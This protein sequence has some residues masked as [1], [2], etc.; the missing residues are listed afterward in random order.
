MRISYNWLKELCPFDLSTARL[1]D[2]LS[3]AGLCVDTY[4]PLG[5]DWS[6]DVEVTSNRPDCLSML[7]IAREVAALVGVRVKHPA[8]RLAESDEAVASCAGLEVLDR[9]LCPHYTAR[10][11]RN[12]TVAPSPDWMLKRLT[13]CGLRPV[14]NVVDITNYVMLEMGQPLHA[15]DLDK[16]HGPMIKV[17]R[18][19]Q[20]EAMTAIDG[21]ECKLTP[22]MCVIADA[23]RAVAIAGVM[24]GLDTEIGDG[25]RHVLLEAA[26]FDPRTNRRTSR[27]LSL[28]SDSS[29]RFERGVDP[30]GVE[31]ASRRAAQLICELAGG[32]LAAGLLED[33]GDQAEPR[34]VTLRFAR[35]EHVLGIE[36]PRERCLQIFR[37]L[38]LDVLEENDTS[39]RVRVPSFRGD[40][41]REIDLIEEVA[42]FHGYDKISETTGIPVKPVRITRDE[43]AMNVTRELLVA[44]GFFEILT[45][46][47]VGEEP[48]Q[49]LN[50]WGAA[51]GLELRTCLSK[52]RTHLRRSLLGNLLVTKKW[53]QDRGTRRVNLFELSKV[54]LPVSGQKLP[55]EK[56]CLSALSDEDD[57]LFVLKGMLQAAAARLGL[58]GKL[59]ERPA[60]FELFQAGAVL[61]V[62][63]DGKRIGLMGVLAESWV[64]RLGLITTPALMEIDFDR[65]LAVVDFDRTYRPLPQFPAIER[66]LAIVLD[67][68]VLWSQIE[69][70][71]RAH[72]PEWMES[73]QFFDI[74]RGKQVPAG[75]K[76]VA[77][78]MTF[79]GRDRTLRSEE[80]DQ[81]QAAILKGLESGL[82]AQLR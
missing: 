66:D 31:R 29:Y 73:I 24:G 80:A 50:P 42:R 79:R 67:E 25:T 36:V 78:S 4:E 51:A 12:V 64:E 63:L 77:F 40:L 35:L 2:M 26:R 9:D 37:S 57:A 62:V 38:E 30:D 10:V 7:G 48:L 6:I 76:S 11:V 60:E 16:L 8:I 3:G 5:D 46:S 69:A 74:Y 44:G 20:D 39:V 32:T 72:A 27:A 13:A 45:S 68:S 1:C 54:Y 43:R 21:T 49:Q 33:R 82:G 17:R 15:F 41:E 23:D 22:E 28:Q 34:D 70:C 18:G 56:L 52:E 71:I 58:A 59:A 75:K 53:N 61:D 55:D 14:N 81:A 19:R 47:L 65:V